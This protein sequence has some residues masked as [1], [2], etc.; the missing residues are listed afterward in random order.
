MTANPCVTASDHPRVALPLIIA[1]RGAS[2]YAPEN[3]LAAF[4]HAME[5]G[6]DGIELDVRLSKDGAA[7]VHH[8][9]SL[10]RTSGKEI[11][12]A[13]CTADELAQADV[14]SWFRRLAPNRWQPDFANE[15]V[16]TLQQ[17]FDLLHDFEGRIYVE[18]KCRE[19]DVLP[20]VRS[21]ATLIRESPR[22]ERIIVKSFHLGSIPYLH[23][24]APGVRT[25]ALFAPKIMS[26]LRK[27]KH[28]VDI[29]SQFG[30]DGVSIHFSLATSKLMK[31]AEKHGLPVAVWTVD[32]S[33][34][35]KRAMK[36]GVDAVI[37]N[38]P[39]RLIELRARALAKNSATPRSTSD[40]A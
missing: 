28:L 10:R 25:A 2:A 13:N 14:G 24:L 26:I 39:A 4:R 6:A 23:S 16:P 3:T 27:E 5:C 18:L 1:H 9:S 30:A 31:K 37:T 15:R 32:R 11:K 29:A 12:I 38:D 8:D 17:T 40:G 20:L 34:L 21:V 22:P 19:S 33:R 35:L 36:L 7:V